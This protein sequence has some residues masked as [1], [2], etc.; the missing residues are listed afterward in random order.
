[1]KGKLTFFGEESDFDLMVF[2]GKLTP[3]SFYE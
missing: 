3:G 1:M 2:D